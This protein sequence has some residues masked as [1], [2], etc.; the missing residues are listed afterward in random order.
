MAELPRVVDAI[1]LIKY[2]TNKKDFTK[3]GGKGSHNVFLSPDGLR[4]TT[5][6]IHGNKEIHIGLLRAILIEAGI[7]EDDF[8]NEW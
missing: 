1:D 6:T 7:S 5:V 2:L 4:R 3:I 8:V